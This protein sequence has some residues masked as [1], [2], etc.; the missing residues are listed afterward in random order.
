MR[1]AILAVV[2]L[3]LGGIAGGYWWFRSS[4]GGGSDEASES[5]G[6]S[7]SSDSGGSSGDD[8]SKGDG[9]S[10]DG[11]DGGSAGGS[12][13]A[14]GPV[15]TIGR[16][17]AP[18]TIDLYEDFLCPHCAGFESEAGEYLV[19]QA[20]QGRVHVTYHMMTLPMFAKPTELAANSYACANAVEPDKAPSLHRALFA[21]QQP[22]TGSSLL[23]QAGE[24]GLTSDE[25]VSCVREMKYAAFLK[26]TDRKAADR[27]VNATPTVLVNGAKVEPG[28]GS[29]GWREA[30]RQ[31]IEG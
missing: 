12:D 9:D 10:S 18:V 5:S 11:G 16:A 20:E 13:A 28:S 30:L 24:A 21:N 22:W 26:E 31:A 23:A 27:G 25:F 29:A 17:D 14:G 19:E 6:S 4:S 15:G 3:L 8:D 2:L 7:D 1:L